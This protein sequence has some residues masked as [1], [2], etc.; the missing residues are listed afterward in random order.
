MPQLKVLV[1]GALPS[2]TLRLEETLRR[3]GYL[4]VFKHASLKQV[5]VEIPEWSSWDLVIARY[6]QQ[7]SVL[8]LSILA[9]VLRKASPPVFFLTDD[10]SPGLVSRL[11]NAGGRRV[12]F[13][14]EMETTLQQNLEG[15]FDMGRIPAAQRIAPESKPNDP[16][17]SPLN[18]LVFEIARLFNNSPVGIGIIRQNDRRCLECNQTFAEILNSPREQLIGR[19]LLEL[20]LSE[21]M[22]ELLK[23]GTQN[24]R[25][26]GYQ[27]KIFTTDRNVRDIIINLDHLHWHGEDYWIIL[28]QDVTEREQDRKKIERLNKELEKLVVVRTGALNVANRELAAE[29]GRRKY[30]EDF[31]DQLSQTLRETPDVVAIS[32]PD[33][34]VQYLNAAGRRLFGLREDEPVFTLSLYSPYSEQSKRMIL[35]VI[36]PRLVK[37]GAWRGE[38]E[39]SL[40][41]GRLIP[42]SQVLVCKKDD[43]GNVMYYASIARDISDYKNVERELKQSRER[44]LTLAEAAHDFI[45]MVSKDGVMEYANQYAC[46]ALG[47]N[48][49]NVAGMAVRDFFPKEFAVNHMQMIYE[50]HEINQ[51]V[52]TEGPFYNDG[53]EYWLGTWLVPV[54]NQMGDLVSVLGI[55]R[56]I[57]EQ[58]KMGEALQNALA[59]ER[60]LAEIRSNFFSMTSHQFRTPL[61]T[62]L[63]SAELLQ[64]Y[65]SRWDDQKRAEQLGRIL[66]AGGRLN[67]MLED[68]LVLGRV[69]SGRYVYTPKDFDLINFSRQIVAEITTNDRGRHV[70]HFQP[71]V[72][73]LPVF[74]DQEVFRR[75]LDNL[76]SNAIK[77]SMAGT[78][79]SVNIRIERND[80][81]LEVAD[82]GVG[83]PEKDLKYLFQPFQRGSNVTDYPG[84]GIGLTII[85]K[86]VEL[87]NAT[88]SLRSKENYGTTF[89]VRFPAHLVSPVDP[90]VN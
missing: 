42:V 75:V 47:H 60:K 64:K 61:S 56:D 25:K 37:E 20:G 57:T 72:E 46:I 81:L 12:I 32:G 19:E 16:E 7:N 26:E 73:E 15:V 59:S 23:K 18:N 54:H 66:E 6:Q 45:Y 89:M 22:D 71:E 9:S 21:D 36:Q 85:Q 3:T 53:K 51:P 80:F 48:P 65:G 52:Y 11:L 41:D 55:S 31:S 13:E 88:I 62:I 28:C 77:Y 10:F 44:Y 68:I 30:L 35:E 84:S 29:I 14:P 4:S 76:L 50:V 5:M 39:F 90:A 40:P 1:L 74:L 34:K 69:E 70:I 82:Q 79:V 58:K 49:E 83:I 86:S 43:G 17:A 67:S 78:L 63:L 38:V 24:L 8:L 87:M 27:Q 2:E 33:G